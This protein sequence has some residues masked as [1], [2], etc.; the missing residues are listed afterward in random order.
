MSSKMN[1][2]LLVFLLEFS[3]AVTDRLSGIW[4][5]VYEPGQG[6]GIVCY[7]VSGLYNL[8]LLTRITIRLGFDGLLALTHDPGFTHRTVI[9]QYLH[10]EQLFLQATGGAY[11]V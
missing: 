2:P 8:G 10:D 4:G 9:T 3:S 1:R 5:V 7:S 11:A 6:S